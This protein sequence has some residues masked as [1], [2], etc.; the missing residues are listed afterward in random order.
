MLLKYCNFTYR[1]DANGRTVTPLTAIDGSPLPPAAAVCAHFG[2]DCTV[3]MGAVDCERQKLNVFRMNVLGA[4]VVP[5]ESGSKVRFRDTD[6]F[7]SPSVHFLLENFTR[8]K[9]FILQRIRC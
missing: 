6:L 7:I 3:Y 8:F 1:V 4:K 9:Y 5:V 2:L